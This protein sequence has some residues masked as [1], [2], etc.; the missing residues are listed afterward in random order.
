MVGIGV[1][2]DVRTVSDH[3]LENKTCI[4]GDRKWRNKTQCNRILEKTWQHHSIFFCYI[5]LY[6]FKLIFEYNCRLGY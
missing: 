5:K 6:Y 1:A 2:E 4:I 3:A